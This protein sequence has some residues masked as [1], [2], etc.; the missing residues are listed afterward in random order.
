M[1]TVT[2]ASRNREFAVVRDFMPIYCCEESLRI[3][4]IFTMYRFRPARPCR[5]KNDRCT[6]VPALESLFL[7]GF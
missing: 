5:E 4:G 2:M 6:T 7:G 3:Q 1:Y